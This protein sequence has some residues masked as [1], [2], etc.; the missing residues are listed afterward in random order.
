MTDTNRLA[1]SHGPVRVDVSGPEDGRPVL[2]IH[3]LS[4]P[5]DVWSPLSEG[6][7]RSGCRVIRFD[8]YGRGQS[9]WDS[10]PLTS[11]LMAEQ[12]LEVLDAIGFSGAVHIISMSNS[13]L[14]ALSLAALEPG[15]VR[16]IVMVA[17]SGADPRTMNRS[18]RWSNHPLIRGLSASLLL[19]RLVRRM[20]QHRDALP[21]S[22][23][24]RSRESYALAIE[25]MR[26][27]PHAGRAALSHLASLP[28]PSEL[29]VIFENVAEFG[30]PITAISFG[31][32][33]D[34][35]PEG[36]E[37]MLSRLGSV[38]RIHLDSGGHMGVL[39]HPE[40][41]AKALEDV[42]SGASSRIR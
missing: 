33:H 10:T 41:I 20:H 32:E 30:F 17:P 11:E 36:V 2:M 27:N 25:S 40:A 7:V 42:F 38:N 39:S 18:T 5:L 16:S 8:L 28:M 35:T 21:A 24:E 29:D 23:S 15:R 9:G 14:I 6:L 26:E 37:S 12:A 4:Y 19:K 13:D 34:S 1:L 3:G 22:A 31:E